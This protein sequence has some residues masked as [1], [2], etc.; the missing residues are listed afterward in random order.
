[1]AHVVADS[2]S[3]SVADQLSVRLGQEY[4]VKLGRSFTF[5]EQ[6]S[7]HTIKCKTTVDQNI[8]VPVRI[9]VST[10][11]RISPT[12][13]KII[14]IV[15]CSAISMFSSLFMSAHNLYTY[16]QI[17]IISYVSYVYAHV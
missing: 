2:S 7:F 16:V 14:I 9:N 13:L 15:C 5:P 3:S 8:T 17:V 10:S 4:R 1:M 11:C 12:I 6:N